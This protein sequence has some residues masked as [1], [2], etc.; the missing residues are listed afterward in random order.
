MKRSCP[1]FVALALL[2]LPSIATAQSSSLFGSRGVTG[3]SGTLSNGL[4]GSSNNNT[5]QFGNAGNMT[6][7]TGASASTQQGFTTQG[8]TSG[9]AG[10][11]QRGFAGNR[12]SAASTQ[13]GAAGQ[14]GAMNRNGM[15]AGRNG[16]SSGMNR[17]SQQN[18]NRGNQNGGAS[19]GA[20]ST[21]IRPVQVIAF[22]PPQRTTQNIESS[23]N[24]DV[25]SAVSQ[26]R[27]PGVAVHVDAEG[28]VTIEGHVATESDRRKAATM[29]G[30]EPG[31]RKVVNK[32]TVS[33]Q[34]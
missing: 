17:M 9:L 18:R 24:A 23:I 8:A 12:L 29:I 13:Q 22:T 14:N 1:L 15:N 5:Q 6:G 32:I 4:G 26:G 27:M 28:T 19:A 16:L 31:V 33:E 2:A 10:T 30:L 20:Q 11:G 25:E 7:F 34:P 3:S 21:P